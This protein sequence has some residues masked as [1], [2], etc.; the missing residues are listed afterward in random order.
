MNVTADQLRV[1]VG[2]LCER[3]PGTRIVG[4]HLAEWQGGDR[5]NLNDATF[6]IAWCPSTLAVSEALAG[7]AAS[8]RLIVL[9]P[10]SESDLPLDVLA[11]FARRRLIHPERWEMVRAAFGVSALDPRMPMHGWMA[12]ALLAAR[13]DGFTAPGSVLDSN[14]GWACVFDHFLGLADGSPDADS[15]L[16]WSLREES[17]QRFRRLE[18]KLA[19]AVVE[20]FTATAGE[21]GAL[22][23][24]GIVAGHAEELLSVGLTCGVLFASGAEPNERWAQATARLEP[25]LGGA[26]VSVELGRAWADAAHRVLLALP[27]TERENW[28]DRAER[29]LTRLRAEEFAVLSTVLPSG[30]DQRLEQFAR[31]AGIALE[32]PKTLDDAEQAFRHVLEHEICDEQP[33]RTRGFEMAIRLLRCVLQPSHLPSELPGFIKHHMQRGAFEDWARRYLLGGDAHAGV[34]EFYGRLYQAFRGQREEA[35]RAFASILSDQ[36]AGPGNSEVIPIE[37]CLT[38]T[39]VPLAQHAPVLLLVMDGMDAGVFEELHDSLVS[40]GWRRQ[41]GVAPDAVLAVL[42]TVTESSRMALISGAVSKGNATSEKQAFAAHADLLSV[43]RAKRPPL[44]FHKGD[45]TEGPAEVLAPKVRNA[46]C[47]DQQRVVGIVLNAVDDHLAKSEQL[48]IA[49]NVGSVRLLAS[50]LNE[51]RT[52]GRALV[53]TSDHGH[54][55]EADGVKLDGDTEGRWRSADPAPGDLETEIG[56]ARVRAATG[57]DRIVLPWSETIRYGYRKNGYHGGATIQEAVVP[58]GVYLGPGETLDGWDPVSLLYP[59]WWRSAESEAPLRL[60][61]PRIQRPKS[62]PE[63]DRPQLD[64][65]EEADRTRE[66]TDSRWEELFASEVFVAQRQLAG[67]GAPNDNRVQAALNGLAE[68]HERMPISA[69]A[70]AVGVPLVRVRGV[71]AGLQRL[72]NVDGYSIIALDDV[73]ERVELDAD[74]LVAQFGLDA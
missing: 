3:W 64:L 51:A 23:G 24:A 59:T 27:Q 50:V 62:R 35:N 42:P 5:L 39:L 66:R 67:R 17:A 57:Q 33:A 28:L 15:L 20:R 6:R 10:L 26:S 53:L 19:D 46:L 22:L 37:A 31:T 18:S 54:V 36:S 43:S 70:A 69:F 60:P 8:D 45:L 1:R 32:K 48:Q 47:D 16:R 65:L 49:W 56:G 52:V 44:L 41:R 68:A 63:S 2:Q 55:L 30:F 14:T 25:F 21:L 40:L 38:Q 9:T 71:I 34:A 11:R 13:P 61:L 12:D 72:L 7:E 74:L 73:M 4:I 29:L 58:V